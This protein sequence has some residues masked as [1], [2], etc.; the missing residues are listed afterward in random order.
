MHTRTPTSILNYIRACLQTRASNTIPNFNSCMQ[1]H[2]RINIRIL[3]H[4]LEIVRAVNARRHT[5][6][7]QATRHKPRRIVSGSMKRRNSR[8]KISFLS[9]ILPLCI[10]RV[11]GVYSPTSGKRCST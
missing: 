4:T 9:L 2:S 5:N 11:W 7:T 6:K 8:K 1:T 10:H 3:T